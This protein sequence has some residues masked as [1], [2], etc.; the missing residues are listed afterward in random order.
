MLRRTF[1]HIPGIGPKTELGI[2]QAGIR[3]WD[4]FLESHDKGTLR[5]GRFAHCLLDVQESI[6]AFRGGNWNYFDRGLP[7]DQKWRAFGD[8]SERVLYVDI[9]TTGM[10]GG[11][12]IT[13][14]GTY[15]GREAKSFIDGINLEQA[16]AEI[17]RYPV[18]VT[19]NGAQF[20]MP[21]IRDRFR[22][23]FF[24]H[25][26]VDLRFPLRRL[27]FAGGLKHIEERFGIERSGRTK[28]L[29]GWDAVHLWHQYQRGSAE[30]LEVLLEYNREDIVNLKP[31][32][33]YV[34]SQMSQQLGFT[35]ELR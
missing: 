25:V 27:G 13:V 6:E 30:A 1:V 29:G 4:A 8:L 12:A 18:V 5:S 31:L 9:E 23:N 35:H 34:W 24:N 14:I 2:W 11:S 28:G 15:D 22:H 26:H 3:D 17:E 16:Q 7:S 33:E 32:M 19:Y 10:T 21:F 20:D